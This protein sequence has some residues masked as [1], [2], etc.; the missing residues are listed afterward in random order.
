MDKN[1]LVHQVN[2][3]AEFFAAMPDHLEAVDG[4]ADHVRKFWEPRMRIAL[5]AYLNEGG[6]G[7][8]DMAR[9]AL[10][11]HRAKLEPAAKTPQP[12]AAQGA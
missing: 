6:A 12:V 2:R 4:V 9:E 5:Y 11:K 3:I 8:H 10:E 7:L 1:N